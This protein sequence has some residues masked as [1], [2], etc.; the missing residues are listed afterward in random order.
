MPTCKKQQIE[1][2]IFILNWRILNINLG[3]MT[4]TYSN[5][6]VNLS[7]DNNHDDATIL[8]AFLRIVLPLTYQVKDS[9]SRTIS[10]AICLWI[11]KFQVQSGFDGFLHWSGQNKNW[12]VHI[13]SYVEVFERFGWWTI[14]FIGSSKIENKLKLLI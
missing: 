9:I 3:G 13:F 11:N 10:Q 2:F 14:D 1:N 12:F 4:S 5:N 8:T 7:F 6:N